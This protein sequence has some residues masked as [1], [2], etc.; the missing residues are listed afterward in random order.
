MQ[1]SGCLQ[2]AETRK[3]SQHK[4]KPNSFTFHLWLSRCRVHLATNMQRWDFI[5]NIQFKAQLL[6][7]Y[8]QQNLPPFAA[9][10]LALAKVLPTRVS[11]K[12]SSFTSIHF[13]SGVGA[14]IVSSPASFP[15]LSEFVDGSFSAQLL[16][17]CG[18][19]VW[20]RWAHCMFL[21]D[22]FDILPTRWIRPQRP[23]L[24]G[25]PPGI[26]PS[27]LQKVVLQPENSWPTT[28]RFDDG[29]SLERVRYELKKSLLQH[30][31]VAAAVARPQCKCSCCRYWRYNS[32][33]VCFRFL[34]PLRLMREH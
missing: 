8:Q 19:V 7:R 24:K 4:H 14:V 18:F 20:Q 27:R 11:P 25:V 10:I 2:I 16:S 28:R 31:D 26:N 1:K 13:C 29:L 6:C 15:L 33:D 32:T 21:L 12:P 3:A 5:R 22:V 23:W 34:S 30:A 17:M 9:C